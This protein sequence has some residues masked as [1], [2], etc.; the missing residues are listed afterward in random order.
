MPSLISD[1]YKAWGMKA[2]TRFDQLISDEELGWTFIVEPASTQFCVGNDS[3]KQLPMCINAS[4]APTLRRPESGDRSTCVFAAS[5]FRALSCASSNR[6]AALTVGGC[7]CSKL[8]ATPF[9][10][11]LIVSQLVLAISFRFRARVSCGGRGFDCRHRQSRCRSGKLGQLNNQASVRIA[12]FPKRRC[13][14]C[15]GLTPE[16]Y[17]DWASLCVSRMRQKRVLQ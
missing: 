4:Q 2:N 14:Q 13:C 7:S 5:G 6:F 16:L 9:V 10:C 1:T 11:R 15:V 12:S 3:R 8:R 17:F